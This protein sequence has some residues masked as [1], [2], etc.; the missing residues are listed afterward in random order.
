MLIINKPEKLILL[1][2]QKDLPYEVGQLIEERIRTAF[3]FFLSDIKLGECLGKV[4]Y[5]TLAWERRFYL[6]NDFHLRIFSYGRSALV[7]VFNFG[8]L[9]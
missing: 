9:L 3:Y 7:L 2:E 5:L 1:T 8:Y 6:K 4:V